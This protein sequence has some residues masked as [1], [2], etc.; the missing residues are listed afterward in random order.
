MK[1]LRLLWEIGIAM[2]CSSLS[3]VPFIAFSSPGVREKSQGRK[4]RHSCRVSCRFNSITK[5]SESAD[6]SPA[7]AA[8]TCENGNQQNFSSE[9]K[10]TVDWTSRKNLASGRGGAFFLMSLWIR[11]H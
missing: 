2:I 5:K 1:M 9:A 4:S 11:S 8:D 7:Y 3:R 6:H 10:P